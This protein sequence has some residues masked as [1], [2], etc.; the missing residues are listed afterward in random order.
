MYF[1]I[2]KVNFKYCA[3]WL[4]DLFTYEPGLNLC[5]KNPS[6]CRF[7]FITIHY[8]SGGWL[9]FASL[10]IITFLHNG[11]KPYKS[12]GFSTEI[13]TWLVSEQIHKSTSTVCAFSFNRFDFFGSFCKKILISRRRMDRFWIKYQ[14]WIGY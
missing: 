7:F 5:W 12:L 11:Q 13:Q 1:P 14:I 3:D 2:H 4:M 9:W 8:Q 6:I 10:M